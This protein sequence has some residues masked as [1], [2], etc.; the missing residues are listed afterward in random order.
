M[1]AARV[2]SALDALMA[3]KEGGE[4]QVSGGAATSDQRL[5]DQDPALR[6]HLWASTLAKLAVDQPGYETYRR[7]SAAHPADEALP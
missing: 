1:F 6:A 5:D 7:L 3:L 2:S 4:G